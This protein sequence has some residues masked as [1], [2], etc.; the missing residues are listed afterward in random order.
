M[1]LQPVIARGNIVRH[2][3]RGKVRALH[4]V[5]LSDWL[6]DRQNWSCSRFLASACFADARE[7][8]PARKTLQHGRFLKSGAKL[9][10]S[11]GLGV[12]VVPGGRTLMAYIP[13]RYAP[14]DDWKEVLH[15]GGGVGNLVNNWQTDML[16]Y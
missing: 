8:A 13:P 1:H 16:L 10:R 15:A 12:Q 4:A 14:R 7:H 6:R 9:A 3:H 2:N 11:D 5:N